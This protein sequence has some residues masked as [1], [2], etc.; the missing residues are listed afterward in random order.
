MRTLFFVL[1][2]LFFSFFGGNSYLFFKKKIFQMECEWGGVKGD[3]VSIVSRVSY[4]EG[5]GD[6]R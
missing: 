5:T 3:L 1:R 4:P 2:T 6:N